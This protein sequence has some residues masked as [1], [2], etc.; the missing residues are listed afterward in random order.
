MAMASASGAMGASMSLV[1]QAQSMAAGLRQMSESLH[2]QKQANQM[3]SKYSEHGKH[4]G[5][6]SGSFGHESSAPMPTALSAQHN[7]DNA[8]GG[9]PGSKNT[10][11]AGNAGGANTASMSGHVMPSDGSGVRA[12]GS[13]AS[14]SSVGGSAAGGAPGNDH[15]MYTK[16]E[17]SQMTPEMRKLNDT[18]ARREAATSPEEKQK[19]DKE[20][21][22][23]RKEMAKRF[24]GGAWEAESSLLAITNKGVQDSGVAAPQIR[25]SI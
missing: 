12:N 18:Y 1:G 22:E 20:I 4:R 19:L 13:A 17:L 10:S 3:D 6:D 23:A 2:D 5:T 21:E 15:P 9:G 16:D 14:G 7:G 25:S 8:A 24:G 11:M